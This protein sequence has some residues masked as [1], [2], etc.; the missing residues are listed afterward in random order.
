MNVIH[1][2]EQ[3][4]VP[5]LSS[6]EG[7]CA[8]RVHSP[9]FLSPSARLHSLLKVLLELLMCRFFWDAKNAAALWKSGSSLAGI[10]S[11]PSA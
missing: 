10:P 9:E 3:K 11:A 5:N 1:V 6:L 4:I 7:H 8:L 2:G